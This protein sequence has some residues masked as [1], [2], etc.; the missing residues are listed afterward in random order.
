M[1]MKKPTSKKPAASPRIVF[2]NLA[3]HYGP[4]MTFAELAGALAG[5]ENNPAVRAMLQMLRYQM[6]LARSHEVT[7]GAT[8]SQRDYGAGAASATEDVIEWAHLLIKRD[9][10][11]DA[12]TGLR[13][14]FASKAKVS[15]Q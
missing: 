14:Q 10:E 2:V 8:G 7:D 4:S 1:I 5:Q 9:T 11:R 3:E 12:L 13:A 6:G 15:A